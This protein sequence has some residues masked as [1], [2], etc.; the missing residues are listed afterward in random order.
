M[1]V[2]VVINPKAGSVNPKLIEEKVRTALFRCDLVFANSQTLEEMDQFLRQELAEKTDFF[3]ICGGDGTINT[4]L[5]SLMGSDG[6]LSKLPPI[7]V[8]RSGTANDLAHEI[9][10]ARRVDQAVRNILEGQVKNI[11][12]IQISDGDKKVYMLTNGGVG[13]PALTADLA[14]Q[15]RSG[16]QKVSVCPKTAGLFKVLAA[17]TYKIVKKIGPGVYS[18]MVAEALRTWEQKGW[19]L[20]FELPGG[21]S[22]ST[23][24]PIVLVNNQ[25]SI[26]KT[27]LPAPYTSNTDGTVNLLLS[28]TQKITDHLSAFLHITKGTVGQSNFFRSFELEEFKVRTKNPA[29]PLTFFGDGEI[30]FKDVQELSIKCLHR[31]LPVVVGS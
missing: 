16:L 2:S 25:P 7:A 6:D 5:Q 12:I 27:F 11:D 21:K 28:E 10:V 17:N 8:V 31:G 1:R 9:G 20:E 26:G 3:L 30:L 29:R 14:N 18:M 23:K 15:V 13:I 4:C 24:A 22:F 19:E